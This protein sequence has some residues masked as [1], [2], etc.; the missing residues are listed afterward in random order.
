MDHTLLINQTG[1]EPGLA[2]NIPLKVCLTR[3]FSFF[4]VL[5]Q[6]MYKKDTCQRFCF[7]AMRWLTWRLGLPGRREK[8]TF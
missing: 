2:W 8:N 6:N 4:W 7:E 1:E 5:E 3:F